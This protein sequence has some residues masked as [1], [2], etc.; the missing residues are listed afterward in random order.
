MEGRNDYPMIKV[1]FDTHHMTW[2]L[3]GGKWLHFMPWL[4]SCRGQMYRIDNSVIMRTTYWQLSPI[5]GLHNITHQA[6]KH[7]SFTFPTT[8]HP[9]TDGPFCGVVGHDHTSNPNC[10]ILLFVCLHSR[11]VTTIQWVSSWDC[12]NVRRKSI[13]TL[14][15]AE[16]VS[17]SN[18]RYKPTF[19]CLWNF[20]QI[21]DVNI[22]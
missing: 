3:S 6:F 21:K 20:Y 8:L 12:G 15:V 14:F 1:S 7:V 13:P 16:L 2:F 17:N 22:K 11:L 5:S 19:Y 4:Q 9:L 10:I 18:I